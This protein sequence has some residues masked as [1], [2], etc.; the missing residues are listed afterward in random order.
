M[1]DDEKSP[2]ELFG[3]RL[4][5]VGINAKN[6]E[7]ASSIAD[8]F[9]ALLGMTKSATP[10]SYFADS[11]V[12]IMNENGR[13]EKGHIGFHVDDVETAEKWFSERGFN[14]DES[15]RALNPD[16]S[17]FLVYFDREIAGFAIHLT[18]G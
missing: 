15:S 11:F 8:Q 14:V 6:A 18:R 12:E 13:G 17:T 3:F 16:G 7:E 10:R 9:V 5:H 2:Q 4:A 1:S